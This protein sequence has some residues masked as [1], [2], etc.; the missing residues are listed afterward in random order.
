MFHTLLFLFLITSLFFLVIQKWLIHHTFGL[1]GIF[2]LSAI[3][4]LFITI[5]SPLFNKPGLVVPQQTEIIQEL[6]SIFTNKKDAVQRDSTIIS[7]NF[8]FIDNAYSSQLIA[9]DKGF[10]AR[11]VETITNRG[12]LSTLVEALNQNPECFDLLICDMYFDRPTQDDARLIAAFKQTAL[13]KKLLLSYNFLRPNHKGFG[14]LGKDSYGNI[15]E[16]ADGNLYSIY[17]P[18]HNGYQSLPYQIYL[19]YKN[20]DSLGYFPNLMLFRETDYKGKSTWGINAYLPFFEIHSE[21]V[22]YPEAFND[23]GDYLSNQKNYYNLSDVSQK[24]DISYFLKDLKQRKHEGK[25]NIIFAGSLSSD[26]DVHQ[27]LYGD[28][29]GTSIILNLFLSHVN[30]QHLVNAG[31]VLFLF[32][33]LFIIFALLFCKALDLNPLSNHR[34]KKTGKQKENKLPAIFSA[35]KAGFLILVWEEM[36]VWLLIGLVI[37]YYQIFS[38]IIN[39]MAVLVIITLLCKSFEHA[40][41]Q[42]RN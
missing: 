20:I 11:S 32:I 27:T 3:L 37:G 38:K 39:I 42:K 10:S 5:I 1:K 30:G 19:H 17:H 18:Y 28:M 22:L 7:D 12:Y 4:A 41:R 26:Q 13:K 14:I 36:Q 9:A 8:V 15:V 21:A 29:H 40:A 6:S 31:S 33:S 25:H 23:Q 16:E 34:V 35:L 2:I 24:E